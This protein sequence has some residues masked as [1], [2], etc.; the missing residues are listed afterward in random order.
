MPGFCKSTCLIMSLPVSLSTVGRVIS[1]SKKPGCW[2]ESWPHA[3]LNDVMACCLFSYS[4]QQG[5]PTP[6]GKNRTLRPCRGRL[7]PKR[8]RNFIRAP[9]C[10]QLV[11]LIHFFLRLVCGASA[12]NCSSE[13]RAWRTIFS[14]WCRDPLLGLSFCYSTSASSSRGFRSC[15]LPYL[16]VVGGNPW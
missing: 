6:N 3:A 4:A 16:R 13:F 8:R 9:F 12:E 11:N 14:V 1:A 10:R 15:F 7:E 2:P 5:L